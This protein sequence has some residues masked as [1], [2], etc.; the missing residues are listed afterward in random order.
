MLQLP[1]AFNSLIETNIALLRI[2]TFLRT[3]EL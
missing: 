3:K 2:Q 1:I